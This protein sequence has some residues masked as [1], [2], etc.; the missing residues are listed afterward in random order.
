MLT[1][2]GKHTEFENDSCMNV[3]PLQSRDDHNSHVAR[4]RGHQDE[5]CG[6][7][8]DTGQLTEKII[9]LAAVSTKLVARISVERKASAYSQLAVFH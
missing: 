5:V 7:P 3:Q 6:G 4:S 8:H 2:N 9:W 1:V